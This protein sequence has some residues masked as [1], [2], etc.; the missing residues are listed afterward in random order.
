VWEPDRV[1]RSKGSA[2]DARIAEHLAVS[3][4]TVVLGVDVMVTGVDLTDDGQIAAVRVRG[5]SQR[6]VPVLDLP[7]PAP[8]REGAQ[9]VDAYRHW[10]R[11]T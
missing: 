3:C 10:V 4:R 6:R 1:S 5:K 2:V 9:W 7:L 11:G 8:P